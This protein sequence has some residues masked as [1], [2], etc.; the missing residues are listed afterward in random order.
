MS[1]ASKEQR[2]GQ[3][4]PHESLIYLLLVDVAGTLD[5]SGDGA[6]SVAAG[7]VWA[8]P[9]AVCGPCYHCLSPPGC[10]GTDVSQDEMT[11]AELLGGADGACRGGDGV[12]HPLLYVQRTFLYCL[13]VRHVT[14]QRRDYLEVYKVFHK[15][16]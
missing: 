3:P 11:V 8:L 15:H 12:A 4:T 16:F 14:F 2:W 10:D 7:G 9:V 6:R 1:K 13:A 5:E